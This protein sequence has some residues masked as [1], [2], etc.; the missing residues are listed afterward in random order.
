MAGNVFYAIDCSGST[1]NNAH[2]DKFV[3]KLISDGVDDNGQT[4]KIIFWASGAA[5][6]EQSKDLPVTLKGDKIIA[7]VVRVPQ[8]RGQKEDKS[9]SEGTAV[10]SVMKAL[11]E[12]LKRKVITTPSEDTFVLVTDG[13]IQKHDSMECLNHMERLGLRFKKVV[14]YLE[15]LEHHEIDLTVVLPF[16]RDQNA[17]VIQHKQDYV[18]GKYDWVAKPLAVVDTKAPIDLKP[19]YGEVQK[20]LDEVDDLKTK[21]SMKYVGRRDLAMRDDLLALQRNLIQTIA[22]VGSVDCSEFAFLR[23]L[24][25]K[26]N[27]IEARD[28]IRHVI[29]NYR[30]TA[31]LTLPQKIQGYINVLTKQCM[32]DGFDYGIGKVADRV[33]RAPEVAKKDIDDLNEVVLAPEQNY[34]CPIMMDVD[35]PCLVITGDEGP[36]L[37]LE[38]AA[39]V[40]LIL[41]CPLEILNYPTVCAKIRAKLDCV[42]GFNALR[43]IMKNGKDDDMDGDTDDET[44]HTQAVTPMSRKPIVGALTFY[45]EKSHHAGNRYTLSKM[46]FGRKLQGADALWMAVMYLICEDIQFINTFEADSPM[47]QFKVYLKQ[48]MEQ[49]QSYITLSGLGIPP[50]IR[51]STDIALWYCV[52]TGILY[53]DQTGV[54]NR[55]REMASVGEE[56]IYLLSVLDLKVEMDGE[57][58]RQLSVYKLFEAIRQMSIKDKNWYIKVRSLWQNSIKVNGEVVLVDGPATKE[59]KYDLPE[60]DPFLMEEVDIIAKRVQEYKPNMHL[61]VDLFSK[62]NQSKDEAMVHNNYSYFGEHEDELIEVCP[63][64]CRYFSYVNNVHWKVIAELRHGPLCK[65][66]SAANYLIKYV[67]RYKVYPTVN[68]LILFMSRK[69]QKRK[70]NPRWTLPKDVKLITENVFKN[71]KEIM[72]S[73]KP[74]VFATRAWTS[75]HPEKREDMEQEYLLKKQISEQ[76]NSN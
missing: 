30:T 15:Q 45:N 71:Y 41:N 65:Q 53:P 49:S 25:R 20:F 14:I 66:L 18:N 67:H 56:M 60:A 44:E 63:L 48:R 19:Y 13:Q 6:Y 74:D 75:V 39:F 28:K 24:L 33:R 57:V 21:I 5:Y 62:A 58:F 68:E 32:D 42:I 23:T 51:C 9:I 59:T 40:N 46:L 61:G 16:T 64:T 43:G 35:M 70:N 4:R 69:E 3:K 2:Y 54:Q 52:Q 12:L 17:E 72:D 31:D 10:E 55:L 37:E 26:G 50:L 1:Q 38:N 76:N 47:I 8:Q 11:E 73:I 36:V 22:E 7:N 27:V 29:R 34:V